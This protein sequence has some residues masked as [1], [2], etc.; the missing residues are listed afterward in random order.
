LFEKLGG[1]RRELLILRPSVLFFLCLELICFSLIVLD[2]MEEN[3]PWSELVKRAKAD[4][5][6][7]DDVLAVGQEITT[8]TEVEE[9]LALCALKHLQKFSADQ[10]SPARFVRKCTGHLCSSTIRLALMKER[11]KYQVR[12]F[13]FIF[14]FYF[15]N[16]L[17]SFISFF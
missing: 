2:P 10:T 3:V 4:I 1:Q 6:A 17:L 9:A 16:L 14:Y 8:R 13:C 15:H 11:E 7:A 12:F 5:A